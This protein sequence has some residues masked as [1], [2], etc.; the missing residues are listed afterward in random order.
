MDTCR[1]CFTSHHSPNSVIHCQYRHYLVRNS[2]FA[3][4]QMWI[5]EQHL[6][7]PVFFFVS[8]ETMWNFPIVLGVTKTTMKQTV[9]QARRSL[10]G[11][12]DQLSPSLCKKRF[13]FI[14][15]VPRFLVNCS[16]L[17]GTN[18][19]SKCRQQC[20]N[21]GRTPVCDCVSVFKGMSFSGL[22]QLIMTRITAK[23]CYFYQ[24]Q[25]LA[26]AKTVG[27]L[28]QSSL[29]RWWT[30][31]LSMRQS[32]PGLSAA[33]MI[34]VTDFIKSVCQKWCH[35]CKGDRNVLWPTTHWY[36]LPPPVRNGLMET[37]CNYGLSLKNFT[38]NLV[39]L[40]KCLRVRSAF[41]LCIICGDVDSHTL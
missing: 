14:W 24:L 40:A 13:T 6:F 22:I 23:K 26:R 15:H 4:T 11:L 32:D 8:C 7:H 30:D 3:H 38:A 31:T 28:G 39:E 33:L 1:T 27:F 18:E 9:R 21:F 34:C 16:L 10:A 5:N 29:M 37:C 20:S 12:I 19:Y 2:T 35:R 36:H 17:S 25:L 41:H